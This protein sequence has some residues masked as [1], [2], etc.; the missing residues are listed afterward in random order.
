VPLL[1]CARHAH[2]TIVEDNDLR[3]VEVMRHYGLNRWGYSLLVQIGC[4]GSIPIGIGQFGTGA[5]I[6]PSLW[7]ELGGSGPT[8]AFS[9]A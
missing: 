8:R 7:W 5:E 9:A 2:T 6:L 3:S 4:P 1:R